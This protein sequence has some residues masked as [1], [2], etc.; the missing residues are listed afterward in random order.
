MVNISHE[1]QEVTA[2]EEYAALTGRTYAPEIAKRN[3]NNQRTGTGN[4]QEYQRTI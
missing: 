2:L 3:R 1:V 4:N